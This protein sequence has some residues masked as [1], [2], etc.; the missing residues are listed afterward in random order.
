MRKN[1]LHHN[2]FTLFIERKRER[3]RNA[4]HLNFLLTRRNYYLSPEMRR[5][6]IRIYA[7]RDVSTKEILRKCIALYFFSRVRYFSCDIPVLFLTN[8]N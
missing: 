1:S 4:G 7:S 8:E 3:I 2:R 6:E 5:K